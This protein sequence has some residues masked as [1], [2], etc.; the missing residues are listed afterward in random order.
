M[1]GP[2]AAQT[3]AET[4]ARSW[5]VQHN[6]GIPGLNPS[7]RMDVCF[8]FVVC[9]LVKAR[10]I[11]MVLLQWSYCNGPIAMFLLRWAYCHGPIAMVLLR[12]AY[13]DGPIAIVL[14][15]WSYYNGPIAMVLLRLDYHDGPIAMVVLRW[16]YLSL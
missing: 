10:V 9:F 5:T 14:M 13:C 15:R 12:R 11:A 2:R 7:K 8:S 4:R 6:T 3:G 1:L 16:A